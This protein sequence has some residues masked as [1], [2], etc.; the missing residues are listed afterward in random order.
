MKRTLTLALLA[1]GL[2]WGEPTGPQVIH[3]GVNIQNIGPTTL[4]NQS[5]DRAIIN[6]NGFSID[7]HELVR[8]VQP[9][10]LSV[11]LNRVVGTDP[12]NILGQMQANGRVFL[13]NPNGVVFGPTAKV[14]VGGLMATTLN[15]SDQDFLAGRYHLTQ[16]AN[17]QLASVVNQGELQVADGGFLLLVAPMVNNQGVIIA[18]AGQ[19]GLV[20]SREATINFDGQGLVEISV[21]NAA[22]TNPGTVALA[23]QAVSEVLRQVVA[24]PGI[25]EAGQLPGGE[26]LVVQEG[27]IEANRVVLNSTQATLVAPGS[28]TDGQDVRVLSSGLAR[29]DGTVQASFVELS[30]STFALTGSVTAGHLLLDPETIHIV[31]SDSPA[32][33]DTYLPTVLLVNDAISNEISR[34]ALESLPAGTQ[35]SLEANSL[36]QV[37]DMALDQ[38]NL[39]PNVAVRMTVQAG[40][41]VFEDRHDHM[42]TVGGGSFQFEAPAGSVCLGQVSAPGGSITIQAGLDATL[43]SLSTFDSSSTLSS[44]PVDIQA[45]RDILLGSIQAGNTRLQAGQDILSSPSFSGSVSGNEASF[46]A[47]NAVGTPSEPIFVDV[48]TISGLAR[49]FNFSY[50]GPPS[51]EGLVNGIN[52]LNLRQDPSPPPPTPTPTPDPGPSPDPPPPPAAP[53]VVVQ[54]SR[55]RIDQIPVFQ[56]NESTASFYQPP[57]PVA[58]PLPAGSSSGDI[59][60]SLLDAFAFVEG[61]PGVRVTSQQRVAD[62]VSMRVE[63]EDVM[64]LFE[65]LGQRGW[66]VRMT[67]ERLQAHKG[68]QVISGSLTPG[69]ADLKVQTQQNFDFGPLLRQLQSGKPLQIEVDQYRLVALLEALDEEGW[70]TR[71]TGDRLQGQRGQQKLEGVIQGSQASLQLGTG[72]PKKLGESPDGFAFL[73]V[74]GLQK[75]VQVCDS[76]KFIYRLGPS[77]LMPWIEAFAAHGFRVRTTD[78]HFEAWR[79]EERAEGIVSGE[80]FFLKVG[81]HSCFAASDDDADLQG[82]LAWLLRSKQFPVLSQTRMIDTTRLKL[83]ASLPRLV[84]QLKR[85]GW[86][87]AAGNLTARRGHYRLHLKPA[88]NSLRLTVSRI[89]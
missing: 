86:K 26:G 33:L 73:M 17:K 40:D 56:I 19:V 63:T 34:G 89:P 81:P 79:G 68:D 16:D 39:A 58:S 9:N 66:I 43:N 53:P 65:A 72:A 61:L 46:E 42:F 69:G 59:D 14:D 15:L 45:G 60:Q 6:W 36:I 3:G 71:M 52:G 18:K 88:G 22:I 74:A 25:T 24:E 20:G 31:D 70:R 57:K 44:G 1:T 47:G 84:G 55:N 10:Q 21:P 76:Q 28:H 30:G 64:P 78:E 27:H 12:S 80:R 11:I 7:V 51:P 8:F 2:A 49:E 67:G 41:I 35:V 32:P 13:I 38:I 50:D 85:H 5:T 87:F 83:Q 4:I 62:V 23:P 82:L 54:D 48:G 29:L 75:N 37:D 77:G